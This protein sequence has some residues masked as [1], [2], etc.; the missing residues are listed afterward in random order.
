LALLVEDPP[1]ETEARA[2]L[3]RFERALDGADSA[4]LVVCRSI[5]DRD[6]LGFDESF[7]ALLAEREAQIRDDKERGQTEEPPVIA[8]RRVFVEGV[9]LLRI[10]E[11]FGLTTQAEYRFCPLLA[12]RQ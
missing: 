3:P 8:Q 9:A 10:A 7:E 1:V 2:L 12:R 6:Q 4:R 11:R 5:L